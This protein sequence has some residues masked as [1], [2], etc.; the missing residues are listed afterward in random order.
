[1]ARRNTM[2]RKGG[3]LLFAVALLA[4]MPQVAAAQWWEDEAA[5]KEGM[6]DRDHARTEARGPGRAEDA[7][8]GLGY[9]DNYGYDNDL[10]ERELY[11]DGREAGA[12]EER[13]A[14][15]EDPNLGDPGIHN[16]GI[17]GGGGPGIFPEGEEYADY[18]DEDFEDQR[19]WGDWF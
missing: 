17:L 7:Q 14:G 15:T 5:F 13:V 9:Y 6:A 3:T 16:E 12:G 4:G 10:Y 1:M 19:T 18:Y 8:T 11:G 2:L